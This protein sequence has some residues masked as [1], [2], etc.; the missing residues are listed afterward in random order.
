MIDYETWCKIKHAIDTEHLSLKQ[1]AH[2]LGLHIRT[3]SSWAKLAH[4]E[5][6]KPVK[7]PSLLDPYKGEITRMLDTHPYTG[8]QILQRL[9]E[10]GYPGGHSILKDYLKLIRRKPM[11]A[12]LKLVFAP[13]EA[14]QA[15]WGE[16]GT[17]QVGNTRR[18]LYFFV[19]VLCHCRLMYLEF[20]VKQTMEHFLAAHEHAFAAFG[21]VPSRVI[22]DNLK[23]GVISHPTGSRPVFN[24]RY[25]DYARHCGFEP[26]ACNK[27]KGNE[28]GRVESGV[29]YVKKNF[30]N[31]LQLADFSAIHPA[32]KLWLE[33]VA[34]VRIHGETHKR[35]ID[36]FEQEKS[37]LRPLN[38]NTY[39]VSRIRTVR[40]SPQFRAAFES[41]H[42]SVPPQYCGLIVTLKAWPDRLCIYHEQNL[43]ARHPR[44]Y[45]RN[46]DIEDPD[47]PKAL[48]EQR[49]TGKEQRLL[50][51]FLAITPKAQQY[52]QG[53][54]QRRLATRN[55][56][57]RINA[58]A[59]IHGTAATA[60][61]IDDALVLGAFS[62]EYIVNLLEARARKLPEASPLH[63][64]RGQDLLDLEIP[65]PDLSLYE[66]RYHGKQIPQK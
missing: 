15:D 42:Y 37:H 63:V 20:T 31:G 2:A 56:I 7:R 33:T 49:T 51:S 21:G 9:R 64:T 40:V 45:D 19:M 55:H 54:E 60:R 27:G 24:P 32:A 6:R 17:I 14:A 36:L 34:N 12:F 59:E 26:V 35:P 65:Q 16:Y 3:V 18:K 47:H 53:L 22:I 28:K 41:N 11:P 39:D 52:L 48:L 46:K 13:G 38:P 66:V 43:I 61:A 58:L 44:S 5:P 1:T 25:L 57:A 62:C 8:Q 10:M 23:T 4:Y 29:G 30:L 50:A